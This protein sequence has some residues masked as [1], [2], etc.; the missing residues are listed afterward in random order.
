[1]GTVFGPVT[2]QNPQGLYHGIVTHQCTSDPDPWTIQ[3]QLDYFKGYDLR[4]ETVDAAQEDAND[5]PFD[6]Q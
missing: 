2:Q 3:F 4:V 1:M 6:L 5:I